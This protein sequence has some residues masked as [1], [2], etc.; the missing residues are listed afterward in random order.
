[1]QY[2][3]IEQIVNN[4][5][6]GGTVVSTGESSARTSKVMDEMVSSYYRNRRL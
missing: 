5:A 6:G 2:Y 3:L 4:L 1:M